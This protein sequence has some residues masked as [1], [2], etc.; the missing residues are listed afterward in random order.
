[1]RVPSSRESD[2]SS[3]ERRSRRGRTERGRE[4]NAWGGDSMGPRKCKRSSVVTARGLAEK[5]WRLLLGT[6]SVHQGRDL[7]FH[8]DAAAELQV[9]D[10]AGVLVLLERAAGAG[11]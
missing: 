8:V 1:M 3:K 6:Q 10:Q 9:R 2:T 7:F 5:A 4:R 11:E